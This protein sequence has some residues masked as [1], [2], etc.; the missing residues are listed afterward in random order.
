MTKWLTEFLT[1]LR[2]NKSWWLAPLCVVVLILAA[3]VFFAH[4]T[5]LAPFMYSH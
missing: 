3:L 2:L 4:G 1:F 5:A